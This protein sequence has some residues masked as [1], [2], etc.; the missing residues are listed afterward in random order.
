[1]IPP[2]TV[3]T[4]TD[5]NADTW[6]GSER[7]LAYEVAADKPVSVWMR[8]VRPVLVVRCANRVT[9]VFV[10]TDSAARIEGGT[11][12]HTVRLQFDDG[13]EESQRWPDADRH[14]ALFAP[15]GAALARRLAGVSTLRF[16]FTPHNAQPVMVRFQVAGLAPLLERAVKAGCTDVVR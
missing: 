7:D 2:S 15:D 1:V 8:S 3:P 4:W 16:G 13:P 6:I 5:A 14:D 11:P 9:D 12:D 10:F